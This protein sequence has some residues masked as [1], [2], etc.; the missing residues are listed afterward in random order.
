[1]SWRSI[2]NESRLAR[3]RTCT[4]NLRKEHEGSHVLCPRIRAASP[5]AA[6]HPRG[7]LGTRPCLQWR[8][9]RRSGESRPSRVS[10]ESRRGAEPPN[11]FD[12]GHDE[13][14]CVSHVRHAGDLGD[15][16]CQLAA[17]SPHARKDRRASSRFPSGLAQGNQRRGHGSNPA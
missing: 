14:V 7:R 3:S 5:G 10:A 15:S 11:T 12:D 8:G 16:R 1:M 4:S 2:G 13:L 6:L 17:H 9:D